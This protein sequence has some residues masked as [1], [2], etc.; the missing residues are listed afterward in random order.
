MVRRAWSAHFREKAA[1]R[2]VLHALL[3]GLPI[4]ESLMLD[5]VR[6]S[7]VDHVLFLDYFHLEI[8]LYMAVYCVLIMCLELKIQLVKL[9]CWLWSV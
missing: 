7:Y 5:G 2:Y 8:V 6:F 3:K 4:F 1:T 9:G